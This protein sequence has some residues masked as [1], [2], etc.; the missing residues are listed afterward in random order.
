MTACPTC[1]NDTVPE[2][3]LYVV[4]SVPEWYS[5]LRWH[6]RLANCFWVICPRCTLY[7]LKDETRLHVMEPK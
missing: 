3:G 1:G 6:C 4:D 5:G 2:E 7:D